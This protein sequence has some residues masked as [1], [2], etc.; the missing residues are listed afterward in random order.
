MT[1]CDLGRFFC[2]QKV[3]IQHHKNIQHY[4]FKKSTQHFYNPN[5]SLWPKEVP[6]F[7]FSFQYPIAFVSPCKTF[8]RKGE[9]HK[10]AQ[11]CAHLWHVYLLMQCNKQT[12]QLR[13]QHSAAHVDRCINHLAETLGRKENNLIQLTETRRDRMDI[14]FPPNP[15]I[16]NSPCL[17]CNAHCFSCKGTRWME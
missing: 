13:L 5:N 17:W 12:V 3:I 4:C 7:F 9:G 14:E 1:Q 10:W 16:S 2:H 11:N 8:Q 15:T 6:M